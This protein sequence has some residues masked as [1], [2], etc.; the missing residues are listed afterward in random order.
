MSASRIAV[1]FDW[2]FVHL[3]HWGP[4]DERRAR[5]EDTTR[6]RPRTSAGARRRLAASRLAL[7]QEDCLTARPLD[8]VMPSGGSVVTPLDPTAPG[9]R[10][11]HSPMPPAAA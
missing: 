5:M 1:L 9:V 8:A 3:E 10:T 4:W 2:G 6:A 11:L 7:S